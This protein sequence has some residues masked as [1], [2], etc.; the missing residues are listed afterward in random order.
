MSRFLLPWFDHILRNGPIGAFAHPFADYTPPYLYLLALSSLGYPALAPATLIKLLSIAST[1]FLVLGFADLL[2]AMGANQRQALLLP[3]LPTVLLNAA[4]LGQCDAIWSGACLFAVA[5]MIRGG[6]IASLAWC[7]VAVAFKAQSAFVAPFI[8]GALLS[9]RAPAWQ[10]AIPGLVY[11]AMM[12]PA[13]LAGWPAADLFT[14]YLRQAGEYDFAGRLA[15]P[16]IWVGMALHDDAQ[17]FYLVGYAGAIAAATGLGALAYRSTRTS[18]AMLAA[19][20][21]SAIAIP[22]I[23]PRM[24]ERYFFLADVLAVALALSVRSRLS[25][26][27]AVG[28]Q[29]ASLM[30]L[31]SYLFFYAHPY[32]TLIGSLFAAASLVAT[33]R[34]LTEESGPAIA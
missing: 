33:W 3:L 10:W 14:V 8:I 28:V 7:G 5:A 16:W 6:T 20:S 9:R 15:T 34:I 4:L 26:I 17:K 2:K 30:S 32:P 22:F 29:L 1:G 18:Q 21:L 13:W 11:A 25:V 12:A 31:L 24:H 23:L 19:A 27:A